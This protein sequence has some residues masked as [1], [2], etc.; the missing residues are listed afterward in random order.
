MVGEAAKQTEYTKMNS[1]SKLLNRGPCPWDLQL[2]LENCLAHP[3]KVEFA[4]QVY[5]S[6]ADLKKKVYDCDVC[7][8]YCGNI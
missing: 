3:G 1:A 6:W 2:P 5:L 8:C 7:G 4:Q